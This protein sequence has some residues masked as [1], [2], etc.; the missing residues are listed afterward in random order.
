MSRY[1]VHDADSAAMVDWDLAV[2]AGHPAGRRRPEVSA[3]RGGDAVDE[4]RAGADR[5][6][7]AGARVHRPGRRRPTPP[8][9]W[10]S[11]AAAGSRPTPTPS[12][13]VI[14]PARRQAAEREGAARRASPR[15]RLAGDRARGRRA[16]GLPRRQGAGPVRPVPR[17]GRP[18]AA[19]RAQHRRTSSASSASTRTTSGSGS[20]C[21]RRPTGCS[22]PR[23]RGCATTCSPRSGA[24]RP[25]SDRPCRRLLA[26]RPQARRRGGS[27]APTA[28]LDR[29]CSAPRSSSEMLDRVTGVMSLLE[30]HADVVM[31]GVGPEVIP[32]RRPRSARRSPSAARAPAP[33]TGC[34]A[35]C[36]ASTP[37]WRSTATA[38]RFVRA[39]RRQGRHGRV[40]R[41]LGRARAPPHQGRD[42]RPGRPGSRRVHG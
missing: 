16:A 23:C 40:Q 13:T 8:R 20:A 12:R 7:A 42:R 36:S 32:H 31:D 22:S 9:C 37:R 26:R 2:S 35:G 1:A 17:P 29:R 38:P 11:T 34:C 4:L 18:A 41:G 39:R 6:T 21:T 28:E 30:G 15:R 25:P 5:S 3:R 33:S 19:G 14:D 10:S 24:H 27:A